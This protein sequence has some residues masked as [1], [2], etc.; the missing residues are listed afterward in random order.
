MSNLTE[1]INKA[2]ENNPI[3]AEM[4]KKFYEASEAAGDP[5]VS[6]Y[7]GGEDVKVSTLRE[8]YDNVFNLDESYIYTASG[9]YAYIV[10]GNEPYELFSDYTVDLEG[11]LSPISEWAEEQE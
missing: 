5:V 2:L 3:E 8:V 9:S 10:M 6:V 7:D 1:Y 4:L 11:I